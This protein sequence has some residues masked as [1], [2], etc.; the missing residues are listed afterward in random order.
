[1]RESGL[2]TITDPGRDRPL[3]EQPTLQCCHC[4]RHFVPRPGSGQVRGWC[5]R[6]NRPVCGPACAAC[7]PLEQQLANLEAGRPANAPGTLIVPGV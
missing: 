4:G 1:M 6:C 7:V 5:L 2:I 3:V